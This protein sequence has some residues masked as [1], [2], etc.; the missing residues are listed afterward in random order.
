MRNLSGKVAVVTGAAHGIGLGLGQRF[1]SEGMRVVLSDVDDAALD[2]AAHDLRARGAQVVGVHT[3]V[4]DPDAVQQ[5][6]D[7]T[8]AEFGE[9]QLLVNNAGVGGLQRFDTISHEMWQWTLG[10]DLWG[11]INGCRIFLPLLA[12][13]E[14][15]WIVNTAS[16][17]GFVSGPYLA[18]YFV[19][20]AAVVTL[21]E[22]LHAELALEHPNVGI[23]VLCP[24][25]T[26]TGI[27]HDERSKPADLA[28]RADADPRLEEMRESVNAMNEAG[29]STAEVAQIVVDGIAEGRLHIFTHPEFMTHIRTRFES[30]FDSVPPASPRTVGGSEDRV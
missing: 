11:P 30:I 5:L 25:N 12:K 23:S 8:V 15:A 20:K 21:S 17:A 26:A 13:A 27:R 7:A 2:E 16:V 3:D 18:P 10:V 22:C 24:A 19:A 1:A 9:V 6:A 4:A 28:S 14:Q 29:M